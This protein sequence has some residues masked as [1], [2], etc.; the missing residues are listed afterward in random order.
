MEHKLCLFFCHSL[1]PEVSQVIRNGNYPDVSLKGFRGN[2]AGGCIQPEKAFEQVLNFVDEYDKIIVVAGICSGSQNNPFLR[3]RKI[4]VV[5]PEQCFEILT[6]LPLIH[7]LVKQGN[8]LVTN[9]WLRNYRQHIQEWGFDEV[10]AKAFFRESIKKILLLDTGLPGNYREELDALAAYMGLAYEI[11]PI[12]NHHLRMFIDALVYKW[13]AET[14]RTFLNDRIARITRES[15][16]Y[17]MLFFHVKKLIDLTDENLIVRE[18][19]S[20]ADILF[21]PQE[22]IF[23]K[24]LPD[25]REDETVFK[26]TGNPDLFSNE[27]SFSIELKHLEGFLGTFRV[28]GIQFPQYLSQYKAMSPVITQIGGLAMVNARKYTQLEEAR[29][30]IARSEEELRHL[31]ATKDKFFSIIAHDLRSPFNSIIGFSELQVLQIKKKNYEKLEQYT[32]IILD[33]ANRTMELLTNLLEWSRSQTGRMEYNPESFD[34]SDFLEQV[35][36]LY[37]D[38]ASQKSIFIKKHFERNIE[39]HADIQMMSTILRNLISNAIKFTG[40]GGEIWVR[41]EKKD[42]EVVISVQDNGIGIPASR[43]GKLFFIDTGSST[44]GTAN[45][46]GSGLGLILCKE[47]IEKHGGRIWMESEEKIGSVFSISLPLIYYE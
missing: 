32:G 5:V 38:I 27:N 12:G 34:L 39:V 14:E 10:S 40:E 29:Q 21:M 45:E 43:A 20:L 11:L 6:S 28:S 17:S 23:Q 7:H 25:G 15:A 2:C 19:A 41:A 46:K 16:D 44:L 47:F 8:Y 3:H 42:N 30:E 18:I 37:I 35:I 33:T 24:L 13:R 22:I 26:A 31:N 36:L 4:E 9:G 1:L